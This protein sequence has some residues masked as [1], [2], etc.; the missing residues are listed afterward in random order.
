MVEQSGFLVPGS[1]K[2][3]G[4]HLDD[5]IWMITPFIEFYR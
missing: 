2:E 3:L 1:W 5:L 4:S